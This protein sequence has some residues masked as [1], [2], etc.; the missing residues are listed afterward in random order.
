MMNKSRI[1]F[2]FM[3]RSEGISP[4]EY[5]KILEIHR[6]HRVPQNQQEIEGELEVTKLGGLDAD[7][8]MRLLE[9]KSELERKKRRLF[10][11]SPDLSDNAS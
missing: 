9:A 10:R 7:R 1:L 3:A 6:R 8:F 11:R 2:N 4:E 5:A